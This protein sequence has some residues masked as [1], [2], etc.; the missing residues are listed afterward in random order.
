MTVR[1][2]GP[3]TASPP[4][5]VKPGLAGMRPRDGFRPTSPVAAAG[6]RTEPPPSDPG[7]NGS[8]PAATATAAPPL[9]P[10]GPSAVS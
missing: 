3:A 6:M 5:F 10:P 2:S 9:E 8:S 1:A 7:A 4:R